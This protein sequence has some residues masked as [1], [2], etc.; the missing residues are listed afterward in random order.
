MLMES[1]KDGRA[2]SVCRV[3]R[4]LVTYRKVR[5]LN[6]N[7]QSL[8]KRLEKVLIGEWSVALSVTLLQAETELHQLLSSE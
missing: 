5:S 7:D 1:L 8:L 2:E 3:I 6:E 4:S